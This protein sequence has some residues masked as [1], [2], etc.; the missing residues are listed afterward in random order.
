M[1][2][3]KSVLNRGVLVLLMISS[4]ILVACAQESGGTRENFR[5]GNQ[6]LE[7]RFLR[8]GAEDFYEG[9][10]LT[11]LVEFFNRGTADIV[12]GRFF[13]T[14]YDL[15]Y[16]RLGLDPAFIN[17]D[18]KSEFDPRG[19]FSQ[20][21]T[22]RSSQPLRMPRNTESFPQTL[23]VSACFEYT[24]LATAEI[25][26][27]PDPHGRR[28]LNKI[29]TMNPVSPGPQGA[30]IVITRVEPRVSGNDFRLT[31]DF[32]NQG[33]G[34]TYDRR[35]SHEKCLVDLDA[36]QDMNKVDLIRVDFSGRTMTCQPRNPIRMNDG[37]GRIV[38][39]CVGCINEYV[40][41]FRTQVSIEMKYGYRQEILKPIRILR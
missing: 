16:I 28:V 23:K 27:D 17:I 38:C 15:S 3:R 1:N 7:M 9:D 10:S 8:P 33:G 31:I 25:C 12:N 26:V 34:V 22:I 40:D 41:P 21:L 4:L 18:G 35:I 19:E 39:D 14:G 2:I 37:R 36:F 11:V 29:C 32:A 13:V 6:A 30:P 5:T 24:T 20:I